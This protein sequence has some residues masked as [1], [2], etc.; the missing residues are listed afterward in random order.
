MHGKSK[1]T[2]NEKKRQEGGNNKKKGIH[3]INPA[4]QAAGLISNLLQ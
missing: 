4:G 1:G 2:N 3:L